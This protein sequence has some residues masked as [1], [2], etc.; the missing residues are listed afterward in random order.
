MQELP[1]DLGQLAKLV[2]LRVESNKLL[3]LP[4]SLGHL[5]GITRLDLRHNQLTSLPESISDLSELVELRV[6]DNRL[7]SVPGSL[8]RLGGLS[9]LQL[10]GN[11]LSTLPSQLGD[12]KQLKMLSID[13]NQF[14]VLP[15]AIGSMR[16]LRELHFDGSATLP[17]E[18]NDRAAFHDMHIYGDCK[19]AL[20]S[21]FWDLVTVATLFLHDLV[22]F[23]AECRRLRHVHHLDLS[24]NGLVSL[25]A[26][27]GELPELRSLPPQWQPTG[28]ATA[29]IGQTRNAGNPESGR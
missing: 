18:M 29:G 15:T 19:A 25:P 3:S 14:S 23:G 24:N 2:E 12:L 16:G 26:E 4:S 22:D 5:A 6:S 17:S 11:N 7:V 9:V 21:A 13:N 20:N 10:N 28:H 1:E 27:L 8:G